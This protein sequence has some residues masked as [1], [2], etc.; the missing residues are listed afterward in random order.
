MKKSENEPKKSKKEE[1]KSGST[2]V[3][4]EHRAQDA[5][6]KVKVNKSSW[7]RPTNIECGSQHS[8]N[9]T[10]TIFWLYIHRTKVWGIR[11]R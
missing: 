2:I 5:N 11:E 3:V 10:N 8:L 7:M 1:N 9:I 6:G 4:H